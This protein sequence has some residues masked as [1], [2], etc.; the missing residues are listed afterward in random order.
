[1]SSTNPVMVSSQIYVWGAK[2]AGSD[3]KPLQAVIAG[4][5]EIFLATTTNLPSAVW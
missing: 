2:G 4:S 1:M 3:K 5:Q